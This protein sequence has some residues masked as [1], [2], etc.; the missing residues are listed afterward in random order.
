MLAWYSNGI[1]SVSFRGSSLR[2]GRTEQHVVTGMGAAALSARIDK[3]RELLKDARSDDNTAIL[4][5]SSLVSETSLTLQ[6]FFSIM[7]LT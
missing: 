5:S 6:R 2:L 4:I 3:V 1:Q 7:V